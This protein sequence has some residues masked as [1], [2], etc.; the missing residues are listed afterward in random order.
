MNAVDASAHFDKP[1]DC[2]SHSRD[3][4][5]L[6]VLPG[7]PLVLDRRGLLFALANYHSDVVLDEAL[8]RL[9]S[10]GWRLTTSSC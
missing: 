2:K 5:I 10:Q 3:Y 9:L 4:V 7:P 1:S 8:P 6:H